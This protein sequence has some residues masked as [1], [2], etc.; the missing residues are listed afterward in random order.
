[1]AKVLEIRAECERRFNRRREQG[2]SDETELNNY[3]NSLKEI[4]AVLGLN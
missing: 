2:S 4:S 3:Q 1:M